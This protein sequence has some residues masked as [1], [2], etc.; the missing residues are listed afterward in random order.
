[1]KK[2]NVSRVAKWAF[3]STATRLRAL[4]E[5]VQAKKMV[6]YINDWR[7]GL[8][9]LIKEFQSLMVQRL[10]SKTSAPNVLD[11]INY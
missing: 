7:G 8:K 5:Y 2:T 6:F 3:F 11:G 1:M 9:I 4:E 10:S